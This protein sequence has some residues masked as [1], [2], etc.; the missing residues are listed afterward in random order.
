MGGY[1]H[2]TPDR[3]AADLSGI[4]KEFEADVDK[5]LPGA[6]RESCKVGRKVARQLAPS[7]HKDGYRSGF[8]YKQRK[9]KGRVI[10]AV[11]NRL[12]PG[13]VHLLEKG[14]ATPA[15]G[16]VAGIPHM[17]PAA[18]RAFETFEREID[19]AIK[20]ALR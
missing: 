6:V 2:T 17:A 15:G 20:G 10:G 5:A 4:L 9:E 16:R 3:F 13:L 14:H 1:V 18:D 12:K 8:T 11:G 19:Q 7:R